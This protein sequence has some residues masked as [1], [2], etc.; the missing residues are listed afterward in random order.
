MKSSHLPGHS[1]MNGS[2]N[3]TNGG[4]GGGGMSQAPPPDYLR[5]DCFLD[6]SALAAPATHEIGAF[7]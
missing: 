1:G 2:H 6:A 7:S 3:S 4:G 5:V